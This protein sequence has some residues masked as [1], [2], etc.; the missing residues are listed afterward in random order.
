M[1]VESHFLHFKARRFKKNLAIPS[2][3]DLIIEVSGDVPSK[4]DIPVITV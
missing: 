4:S 1:S 3:I 2:I